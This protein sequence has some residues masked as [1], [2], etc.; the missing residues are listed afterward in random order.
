MNRTSAFNNIENIFKD[1]ECDIARLKQALN[2]SSEEA[3]DYD[4][5]TIVDDDEETIIDD[6]E[7]TIVYYDAETIA[8]DDSETVI[9]R[10]EELP[11]ENVPVNQKL[12][13][14]SQCPFKTKYKQSHKDHM[15]RHDDSRPLKCDHAG[16]HKSFKTKGDLKQHRYKHDG[17]KIQCDFVGCDKKFTYP[18]ELCTHRKKHQTNQ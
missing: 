9:V 11:I 15:L 5:E 18:S 4:A 16:C 14:C 7:E 3:A 2:V 1:I 13:S 6:D 17:K 8:D 12:Y 10:N